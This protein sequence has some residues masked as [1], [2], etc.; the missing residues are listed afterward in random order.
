[1]DTRKIRKLIELVKET[2]IGELEVKSGEESVRISCQQSQVFAASPQPII[3]PAESYMPAR[4]AA[5]AIPSAEMQAPAAAAAHEGHTVLSPMVGTVYL[6]PSSGA[7][8]FVQVGD[9]VKAGDTLCLI[10]A[11]KMF[12]KIEADISGVISARLIQNEQPV[13]YGQPLFI[14]EPAE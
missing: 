10:E 11:M 7:M 1:M 3:A 4:A 2:G 12:N 8:P 13:E 9:N 6:A 5:A 14:I